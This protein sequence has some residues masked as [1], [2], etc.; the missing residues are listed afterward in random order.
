MSS[1]KQRFVDLRLFN[2]PLRHVNY[3]NYLNFFFPLISPF[4][5]NQLPGEWDRTLDYLINSPSQCWVLKSNKEADSGFEPPNSRSPDHRANHLDRKPKRESPKKPHKGPVK[6]L[7]VISVQRIWTLD[8]PIDNP[9]HLPLNH[10]IQ[11]LEKMAKNPIIK[12]IKLI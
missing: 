3:L 5:F 9:K 7:K 8:Y 1:R 10:E 4:I 6:R 12:L 11:Y 2:C